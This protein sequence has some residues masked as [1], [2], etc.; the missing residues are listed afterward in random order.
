MIFAAK[1]RVVRGVQRAIC[2]VHIYVYSERDKGYS[3][4]RVISPGI[5]VCT[6]VLYSQ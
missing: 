1:T 5:S 2:H 6:G 3:L 4:L